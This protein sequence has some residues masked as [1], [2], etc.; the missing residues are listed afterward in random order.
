MNN[1]SCEGKVERKKSCA[2]FPK[3]NFSL[4]NQVFFCYEALRNS[5]VRN[6]YRFFSPQCMN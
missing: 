6:L 2:T 3:Y 1:S 4:I 5:V